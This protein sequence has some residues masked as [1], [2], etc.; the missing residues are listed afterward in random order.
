MIIYFR[1]CEKQETISH[2]N[3]YN[4]VSKTVMIKK[5]WLSLQGS[6]TAEDRIIIL[7]DDV[8][9]ETLKWLLNTSNTDNI[10]FVEVL[11]HS[12]DYH[13][14]T[15]ML[16]D[17]L[18]Q[19]ATKNPEDLHFILEDD[20]LH[21]PNTLHVLKA[22]LTNWPDF[23]VPYD[24]IDRYT[25]PENTIVL[26]GPDR[27]WRTVTSSTMTVIAKGS[28]WLK[29]ITDLRAAAPTSNDQVFSDI[30]KLSNCISP[31]PGLSSHM[32]DKHAT[33]YVDWNSLWDNYNVE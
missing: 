8:K 31:L 13:G 17:V 30:Y 5:C 22:T 33:P 29:Y 10:E 23:A 15:V 26:L 1:A 20:Y 2:V 14:H 27:H 6:V 12:W 9:Q 21:V 4:N 11:E 32:T 3:R 19:E 24:Y 7:H 18:E 28:T 16:I 25:D